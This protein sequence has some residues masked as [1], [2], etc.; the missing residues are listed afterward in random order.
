MD[1]TGEGGQPPRARTIS[2]A[3]HVSEAGV[4]TTEGAARVKGT[5]AMKNGP[6]TMAPAAACPGGRH[7]HHRHESRN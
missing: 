3:A 7:R 6:A 2:A 5:T 1:H 4:T